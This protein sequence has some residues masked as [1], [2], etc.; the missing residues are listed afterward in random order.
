[1]GSNRKMQDIWCEAEPQKNREYAGKAEPFRTV[2]RQA[3]GGD[4]GVIQKIETPHC[5]AAKPQAL[6]IAVKRF[7]PAGSL[8][9]PS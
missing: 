6:A 5:A 2:R 3:A 4:R 7:I 8:A 9:L 1:V